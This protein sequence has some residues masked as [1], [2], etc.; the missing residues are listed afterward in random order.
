MDFFSYLQI[1]LLIVTSK[2]F[3]EILQK[4]I[5]NS[6][7]KPRVTYSILEI[8][9]LPFMR[10]EREV[11]KVLKNN[12]MKFYG[13]RDRRYRSKLGSALDRLRRV[14]SDMKN[15]TSYLDDYLHLDR[16]KAPEYLNAKY[17]C[18]VWTKSFLPYHA[19]VIKFIQK[20]EPIIFFDFGYGHGLYKSALEEN[21]WNIYQEDF[22]ITTF[23]FVKRLELQVSS[24]PWQYAELFDDAVIPGS[25]FVTPY[26][27]RHLFYDFFVAKVEEFLKYGIVVDDQTLFAIF[28]SQNRHRVNFIETSTY[29]G[30]EK[31]SPKYFLSQGVN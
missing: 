8:H 27:H 30:I 14:S 29:S 3:K 4:V 19:S 7:F 24:D 28:C 15:G 21:C 9:Q 1:D 20:S 10:Y 13:L 12:V 18:L 5:A 26:K 31:W 17:L 23:T 6:E 2:E 16:V 22:S 11:D 25:F